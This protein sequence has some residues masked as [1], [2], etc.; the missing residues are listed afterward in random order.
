[1]FSTLNIKKYFFKNFTGGNQT[2]PSCFDYYA[3]VRV[4]KRQRV[5]GATAASAGGG[6]TDR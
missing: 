3:G 4:A 6:V 5:R 1:M 2:R